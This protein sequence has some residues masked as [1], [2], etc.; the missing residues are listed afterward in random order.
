MALPQQYPDPTAVVISV[1]DHVTQFITLTSIDSRV[2]VLYYLWCNVVQEIT[3]PLVF[4]PEAGLV[5]SHSFVTTFTVD[6]FTINLS[7]SPLLL[8][9]P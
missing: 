5:K 1:L 3:T 2:E 9:S 4:M 7:P 6:T 8:T